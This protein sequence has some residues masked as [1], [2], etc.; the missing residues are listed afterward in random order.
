MSHSH[1]NAAH[2]P[3]LPDHPNPPDF[4]ALAA[5]LQETARALLALQPSTAPEEPQAPSAGPAGRR[6]D[7][8]T[9]SFYFP[10]GTVHLERDLLRRYR[11]EDF[12]GLLEEAHTLLIGLIK[13]MRSVPRDVRVKGYVIASLGAQLDAAALVLRMR[14]V[15]DTVVPVR[16]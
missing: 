2:S 6:D 7:G 8:E 9:R 3:P 16:Q 10:P 1:P 14:N 11:A 4:T 15:Y 13:L 12:Q 5:A